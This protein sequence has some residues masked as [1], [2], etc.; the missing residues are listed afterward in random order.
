MGVGTDFTGDFKSQ[1]KSG[2]TCL[3][4]NAWL[5]PMADRVQEVFQLEPE[6]FCEVKADLFQREPW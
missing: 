3:R 6:G 4:G 5:G 1:C 2:A